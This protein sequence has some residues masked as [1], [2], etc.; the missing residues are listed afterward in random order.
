[1]QVSNHP[2]NVLR[3]FSSFRLIYNVY[4]FYSLYTLWE[5]AISHLLALHQLRHGTSLINYMKIQMHGLVPISAAESHGEAAYLA[6]TGPWQDDKPREVLVYVM[7]DRPSIP[8]IC[9]GKQICGE[10]TFTKRIEP[11]KYAYQAGVAM[12]DFK[13]LP[14]D[15]KSF[16][17]TLGGLIGFFTPTLKFHFE[18][19]DLDSFEPDPWVPCLAMRTNHPIS[20]KRLGITGALSMGLNKRLWRRIKENPKKFLIG[21]IQFLAAVF[22]TLNVFRRGLSPSSA[23]T[24]SIRLAAI[25]MVF[26]SAA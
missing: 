11:R 20:P 18:G 3:R 22:L 14:V 12:W 7:K 6:L 1:M 5:S 16:F 21:I 19:S 8:C 23:W 4:H 10:F 26:L 25:H 15:I 24:K 13:Q 2:T 9:R 17:M